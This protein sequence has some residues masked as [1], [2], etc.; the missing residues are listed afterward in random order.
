LGLLAAATLG[1]AGAANS[2]YAQCGAY[3]ITQGSGATIIPGTADTGNHCD[4]CTTAISLPFNFSF[5]GAPYNAANISS[6]GTVQ[7]TTLNGA[8][9]NECLPTAAMGPTIFPFWDDLYT[10]DGA[11]GRAC[12]HP[13][14]ARPPTASSTSSTG[15]S[16]AAPAARH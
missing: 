8:Y 11:S 6:N 16:S 4:D 15:R 5:Y 10:S 12:S 2:A 13:R 7:F 3:N 14:R 9:S 1:V